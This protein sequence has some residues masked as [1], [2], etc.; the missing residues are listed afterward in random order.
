MI[1]EVKLVSYN[2]KFYPL[3][4]SA[5]T[6]RLCTCMKSYKSLN[7]FCETTCLFSPDFTRGLLSSCTYNLLNSFALLNKLTAM[8]IYGKKHLK[9]FFSR[10]KNALRLNLGI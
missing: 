3:E 4:V 6:L 2:K 10:T 5:L 7:V 8:P 9:I 1:K